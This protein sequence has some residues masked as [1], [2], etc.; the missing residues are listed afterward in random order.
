MLHVLPPALVVSVFAVSCS[1]KLVPY[2]RL[3][4]ARS[5]PQ[6]VVPTRMAFFMGPLG[7]MSQA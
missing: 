3:L 7:S 1:F 2:N 6:R 4:A 5:G